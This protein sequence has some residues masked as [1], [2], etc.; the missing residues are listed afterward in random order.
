MARCAHGTNRGAAQAPACPPWRRR[1]ARGPRSG[2]A[3]VASGYEP[4]TP[5]Q[6]LPTAIRGSVCALHRR[7]DATLGAPREVTER[8][9]SDGHTRRGWSATAAADRGQ[10]STGR[11]SLAGEQQM[12]PGWSRLI[13]AGQGRQVAPSAAPSLHCPQQPAH[14]VSDHF[15]SGWK[16]DVLRRLSDDLV[17]AKPMSRVL[18]M[19]RPREALR[20]GELE[21]PRD[22]GDG[23]QPPGSLPPPGLRPRSLPAHLRPPR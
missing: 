8:G 5:W 12:G 4:A 13:L 1:S 21:R 23:E 3:R 15:P 22:E 16:A 6:R 14:L 17:V 7:G 18:A 19:Y 20:G 2:T 11:A 9:C 10:C